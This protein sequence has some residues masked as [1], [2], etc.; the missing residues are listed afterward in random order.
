MLLT[1]IIILI[2]EVRGVFEQIFFF[3]GIN[4]CYDVRLGRAA[5]LFGFLFIL[6]TGR[7]GGKK[8]WLIFD[9]WRL[10]CTCPQYKPC[11]R[12]FFSSLPPSFP[13]LPPPWPPRPLESKVIPIQ[14]DHLLVTSPPVAAMERSKVTCSIQVCWR[15]LGP[16]QEGLLGRSHEDPWNSC[17]LGPSFSSSSLMMLFSPRTSSPRTW[18]SHHG[19]W[20]EFGLLLQPP[21]FSLHTKSVWVASGRHYS[22]FFPNSLP[23]MFCSF[24]PSSP[25]VATACAGVAS[26][27]GATDRVSGFPPFGH[28]FYNGLA[29]PRY[30]LEKNIWE[31]SECCSLHALS[32]VSRGFTKSWVGQVAL[33]SPINRHAVEPL[34]FT[35]G[36]RQLGTRFSVGSMVLS[37]WSAPSSLEIPALRVP[38]YRLAPV[39]HLLVPLSPAKLPVCYPFFFIYTIFLH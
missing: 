27:P 16:H 9:I 28:L 17:W 34:C 25:W 5:I 20:R 2:F 24:R 6:P 4:M 39:D 15:K 33:R 29:G 12:I 38:R 37:L 21:P 13:L 31:D 18:T 10:L 7:F 11:P 26:S 8:S 14:S 3:R 35:G 19:A 1:E 22:L 23:S 30:L 36:S 32:F